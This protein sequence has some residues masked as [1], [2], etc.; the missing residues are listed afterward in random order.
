MKQNEAKLNPEE[1]DNS[2]YGKLSDEDEGYDMFG[3][4]K[5]KPKVIINPWNTKR[6]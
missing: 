5:V 2:E 4:K 3:R 1:N 6:V